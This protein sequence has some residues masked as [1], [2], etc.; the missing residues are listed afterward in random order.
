MGRVAVREF[1]VET[2]GSRASPLTTRLVLG[3]EGTVCVGSLPTSSRASVAEAGMRSAPAR[4]GCHWAN[5]ATLM[6]ARLPCLLTVASRVVQQPALGEM[7]WN[8]RD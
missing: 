6:P 5:E 8:T 4:R 2:R 1:R 3:N 7:G